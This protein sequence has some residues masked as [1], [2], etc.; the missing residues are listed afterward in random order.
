MPNANGESSVSFSTSQAC[1]VVCI[2]VPVTE[3]TWPIQNRRKLRTRRDSKPRATAV[4][5]ACI[6]LFN[7]KL[8]T[9]VDLVIFSAQAEGEE[10][11]SYRA[12]SR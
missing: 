8:L 3:M 5:Q 10:H 7:D 6:R 12:T 2:Q 1:A 4:A 9:L 11:I